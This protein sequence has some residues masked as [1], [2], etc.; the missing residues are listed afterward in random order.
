MNASSFGR[1][2]KDLC[3]IYHQPQYPAA[4][5][6]NKAAYCRKM[7]F[8]A[9]EL[10]QGGNEDRKILGN[11]R[12]QPISSFSTPQP[13]CYL[14]LFLPVGLIRAGLYI[15]GLHRSVDISTRKVI[16]WAKAE[17]KLGSY[18]SCSLCY[19]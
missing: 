8:P 19:K 18:Y 3:I 13:V 9:E 11:I 12:T 15:T 14:L 1:N 10:R 7:D 16:R 5:Y 4:L 17:S 2:A 6:A